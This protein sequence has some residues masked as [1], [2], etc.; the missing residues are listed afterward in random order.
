MTYTQEQKS[1]LRKIMD[2]EEAV[3]PLWKYVRPKKQ[4]ISWNGVSEIL[5]KLKW[6]KNMVLLDLPCGQGGLSIPLA[7]KY[8]VKVLGYDILP[9][10]VSYANE[11]AIKKVVR[12]LCSFGV[13]DIREVAKKKNICDVL[14]WSAP[15]H[16]FGKAKPTVKALRNLVKNDGLVV[17]ADSYL[18]CSVKPSNALKDY[19]TLEKT[20]QGY[21]AFGDK[22]IKF[23]D[24]RTSQW[25]NDYIYTKKILT[26]ALKRIP[27]KQKKQIMRNYIKTLPQKDKQDKTTLG[28]ALWVIRVKK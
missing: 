16:V 28:S 24:L 14:L 1:D 20:N 10:W 13:T 22:I 27:T 17:I 18:L 3:L 25:K 6:N 2:T 11:L 15:P 5:D 9:E 26:D 7:N 4:I 8:G 12:S 21:T 19:E 23:K